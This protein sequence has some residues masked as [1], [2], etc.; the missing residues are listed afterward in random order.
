MSQSPMTASFPVR[1]YDLA[2]T[3]TSGQAFRWKRCGDAWQGIISGRW[4]EL[5][6]EAGAIMARAAEAQRDWNGC[7]IIC[8]SMSIWKRCLGHFQ[9]MTRCVPV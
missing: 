9:M 7:G 2:A 5:R 8:R 3:L 4:V 1:D 6:Q